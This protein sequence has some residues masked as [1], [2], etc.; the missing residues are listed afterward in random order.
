[1]PREID[2]S[3]LLPSEEAALE[4][5]TI[6]LRGGFKV[7]LAKLDEAQEDGLDWEIVVYT[8]AVPTHSDITMLE[9]ALKE[10]AA[11]LGGRMSG[12]SALFVDPAER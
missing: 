5:A 8:T 12:W 11:P 1:M 7:E 6:C 3:V 9:A 2:F 4:F 10:Q